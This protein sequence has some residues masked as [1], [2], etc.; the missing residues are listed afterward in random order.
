MTIHVLLNPSAGGGRAGSLRTELSAAF[1]AQGSPVT[2]HLTGEAGAA[3][4]QA[5]DLG[6]TGDDVVV[7]AGGDGTL[8]EVVN[9]LMQCPPDRRPALG[10][11]P[12]GTGNAFARELGLLP[13]QWLEA[14]AIVAAGHQRPVDV[15]LARCGASDFHFLN[16][17][18]AGFVAQAARAAQR[19]KWL[20]RG[21]YTVG[22]L[23]AVAAMRSHPMRVVVDGQVLEGRFLMVEVSNSRYTGTH[24][25]MAPGARLDDGLLDVTLVRA[26][27]RRRLL[28]L[29][30]SIYDGS[31]VGF[32]E[33]TVLQG[34]EIRLDAGAAMPLVVDGELRGQ[35][36][37]TVSCL[38]G[39]LQML[40]P[41]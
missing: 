12:L 35:A 27:P 24:F 14:V 25:L 15:G 23:G 36:P 3:T 34:R 30:P 11:V 31:H 7:A 39:A 4:R 13:G 5:R 26:L 33:V 17:L 19:C 10:L 22:T 8:H 32:D 16:I 20:G 40:A 37:V 18:G 29:F 1:A 21:A 38:P 41:E 2:L 6:A 28:Q 9:G